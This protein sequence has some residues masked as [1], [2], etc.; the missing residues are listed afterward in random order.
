VRSDIDATGFKVDAIKVPV[1]LDT[2]AAGFVAPAGSAAE[3]AIPMAVNL[4]SSI[5]TDDGVGD[6]IALMFEDLEELSGIDIQYDDG[7]ELGPPNIELGPEGH[8]RG[9]GH[10][11]MI[12]ASPFDFAHFR[13][14]DPDDLQGLAIGGRDEETALLTIG[15]N[16]G[17]T[18]SAG[19][20]AN[21]LDTRQFSVVFNRWGGGGLRHA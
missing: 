8:R 15:G 18:R 13:V 1:I 12:V 11:H 7:F 10:Q 14:A 4:G 9:V 16:E 20:K 5:R 19:R 17:V 2:V 21:L 3:P 6:P